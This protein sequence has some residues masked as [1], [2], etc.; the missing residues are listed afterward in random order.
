MPPPIV[1]GMNTSSAHRRAKLGRGLAPLVGRR[2]VE[3]DDLV[4]ALVLVA[5][6]QLD[7]VAGVPDVDEVGALDHA[8]LV[9]V[10]AGN[11]PLEQHG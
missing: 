5:G 4:G 9:H 7:G 6:G 1:N 11:D 8:A 3:E 2:D 10:E